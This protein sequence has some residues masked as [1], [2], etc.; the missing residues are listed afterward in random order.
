MT[1]TSA[2]AFS[3]SVADGLAILTFDHPGGKPN[4]FTRQVIEELERVAAELEARRDLRGLILRS[5]KP[6]M[7]SAGADLEE[8]LAAAALPLE[9]KREILQRGQHLFRRLGR[10]PCPTVAAIDGAAVGGGLGSTPG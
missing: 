5:G 8:M 3:L 2:S 6:G 7:F 1:Q 4:T 9:G 10:L